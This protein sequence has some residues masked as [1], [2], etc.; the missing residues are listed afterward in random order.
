MGVE[1]C[2]S[3]TPDSSQTCQNQGCTCISLFLC[4]ESPVGALAVNWA[5][6]VK[7][8]Y[9]TEWTAHTQGCQIILRNGK[10]PGQ[11]FS[12]S[13]NK[14]RRARF[15]PPLPPLMLT[16]GLLRS[17]SHNWTLLERSDQLSTLDCQAHP[18]RTML[19][20]TGRAGSR[21]HP[22]EHFFEF[23]ACAC[24]LESMFGHRFRGV[25]I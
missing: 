20:N 2:S 24:P 13:K 4:L 6:K 3:K 1:G 17:L 12:H 11:A 19:S 14:M 10:T 9:A 15:A 5:A 7:Q 16:G 23:L 25:L 21:K 8:T 22:A 18:T